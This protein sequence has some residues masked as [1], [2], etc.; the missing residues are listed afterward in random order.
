MASDTASEA[1][2]DPELRAFGERV[3]ALRKKAGMTQEALAHASGLH[4]TYVSQIERGTRNLSLKN[5]LRLAEG[6]GV[7]PAQLVQ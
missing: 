5:I 3:R 1:E 4:W 6:L 2:R 7:E